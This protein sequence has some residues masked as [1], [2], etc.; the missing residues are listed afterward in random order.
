MKSSVKI[1]LFTACL[2]LSGC[3]SCWA[4]ED[5]HKNGADVPE[6]SV[7]CTMEAMLCPDGSSVGRTGPNCEFTPC[8]GSENA[9]PAPD[10]H[11]QHNHDHHGHSHGDHGH[12][13]ET[14]DS[15][16]QSQ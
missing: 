2:F 6:E 12:H 9:E 8:P 15:T 11:S 3:S 13:G 10:D 5:G 7:M 4:A 16:T 1:A 14:D